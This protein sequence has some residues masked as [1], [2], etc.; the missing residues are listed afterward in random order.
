MKTISLAVALTMLAFFPAYGADRSVADEADIAAK[1]AQVEAL[2]AR[3][4]LA[5]SAI[6]STTLLEA[7]NLLRQL[8]EARPKKRGPLR[9]QLEAALA[10]LELEISAAGR[11]RP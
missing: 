2:R 8:R 4:A 7:E 9:S 6:S 11:G 3:A 5:P 1:T 10:R